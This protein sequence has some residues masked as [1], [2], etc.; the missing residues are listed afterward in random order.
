MRLDWFLQEVS[1]FARRITCL[2]S[3]PHLAS[4]SFKPI[5]LDTLEV[6]SIPVGDETIECFMDIQQG[7]YPNVRSL[8]L[9]LPFIQS[10]ARKND[11]DLI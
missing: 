5:M 4:V 10:I 2:T 3:S 1:D 7:Q 8:S 11:P 9:Y 6:V